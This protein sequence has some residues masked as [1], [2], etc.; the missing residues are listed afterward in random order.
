[1]IDLLF[2]SYTC[3]G[4]VLVKAFKLIMIVFVN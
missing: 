1:M 2:L 4:L 3:F